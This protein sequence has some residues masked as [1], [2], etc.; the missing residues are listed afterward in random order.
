MREQGL[1]RWGKWRARGRSPCR[2]LRFEGMIDVVPISRSG[3]GWQRGRSRSRCWQSAAS[4]SAFGLC[5]EPSPSS[6]GRLGPRHGADRDTAQRPDADRRALTGRRSD[7][8][9]LDAKWLKR[10]QMFW[11]PG[12]C[13]ATAWPCHQPPPR[14]A[15]LGDTRLLARHGHQAQSGRSQG[16]EPRT[17]TSSLRLPGIGGATQPPFPAQDAPWRQD[18]EAHFRAN[19]APSRRAVEVGHLHVLAREAIG[20]RRHAL[21]SRTCGLPGQAGP[22]VDDAASGIVAHRPKTR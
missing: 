2:M 21:A 13:Q 1:P 18:Y 6:F 12:T 14:L 20:S 17:R 15:C 22:P 19:H 4:R 10:H 11:S 5:R 9:D 3:R 16:H 7:P 8:T